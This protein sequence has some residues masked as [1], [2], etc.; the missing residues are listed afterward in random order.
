MMKWME[1]GVEE[2]R[3]CA[4]YGQKLPTPNRGRFTGI[5]MHEILHNA[6]LEDLER[7]L[8][9]VLNRPQPFQQKALKLSEAFATWAHKGAPEK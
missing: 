5:P 1:R 3:N 6:S 8:S 2:I 9:F 4:P 7:F